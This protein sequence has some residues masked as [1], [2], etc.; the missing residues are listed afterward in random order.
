M[1]NT[2]NFPSQCDRRALNPLFHNASRNVPRTKTRTAVSNCARQRC[3]AT[4]DSNLPETASNLP[5]HWSSKEERNWEASA[6]N[7]RLRRGVGGEP[8]APEAAGARRAGR[9]DGEP[10]HGALQRRHPSHPRRPPPPLTRLAHPKP[11][12]ITNT[13]SSSSRTG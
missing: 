1:Q 12:R 11:Q 4:P 10:R 8:V 3:S 5:K 2:A 13:P 9:G 7:P 6:T